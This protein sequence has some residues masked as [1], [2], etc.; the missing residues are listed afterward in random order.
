[1]GDC[2]T[3][4]SRLKRKQ[5]SKKK[6]RLPVIKKPIYYM[7]WEKKYGKSPIGF[8]GKMKNFP[9]ILKTEESEMVIINWDNK[10]VRDIWGKPIGKVPSKQ[11]LDTFCADTLEVAD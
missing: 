4:R 7:D 8:V 3:K 5:G 6:T 9:P 2:I 10:V 1:M 11:R